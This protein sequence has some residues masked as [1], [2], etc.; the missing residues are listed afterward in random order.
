[1]VHKNRYSGSDQRFSSHSNLFY[2]SPT[3]TRNLCYSIPP[4][5]IHD[6]KK[7]NKLVGKITIT[8]KSVLH[9]IQAMT[10]LWL[11]PSPPWKLITVALYHLMK[12]K[13]RTLGYTCPN[14][15]SPS[16][17]WPAHH[18]KILF[19]PSQTLGSIFQILDS[20]PHV[21]PRQKVAGSLTSRRGL[22][23]PWGQ[24][25][26]LIQEYISDIAWG[27]KSGIF[28]SSPFW[29]MALLSDTFP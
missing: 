27:C 14:T 9:N 22:W 23:T 19:L 8:L 2:F 1:M 21:L 24:F 20:L 6:S 4:S 26:L 29:G 25:V 7:L 13:P 10:L 18:L 17:V 15:A 12:Q 11:P 16:A 28:D 3:A 5:A